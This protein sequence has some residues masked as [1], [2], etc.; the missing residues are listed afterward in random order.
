M[1]LLKLI[2]S[3]LL[4]F[5]FVIFGMVFVFHNSAPVLVD[6]F[7]IQFS[8]MGIGFW[9]FVS[10][11]LGIFLGWLSLLPVGILLK[12]SIKSSQRKLKSQ[13][14]ELSHLKGVP[15]KGN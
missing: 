2:L 8:S 5:I 1:A 14:N 3:V 12:L 10:L 4:V 11:I 7:L 6:F 15:V 9:I 13:A